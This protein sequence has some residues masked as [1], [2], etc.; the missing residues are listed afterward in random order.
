MRKSS[1]FVAIVCGCH[2]IAG[3]P[4]AASLKVMCSGLES[5]KESF[6]VPDL[7]SDTWTLGHRPAC[8]VLGAQCFHSQSQYPLI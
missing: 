1:H 8:H 4:T 2:L 5:T 7:A 3:Q 6:A